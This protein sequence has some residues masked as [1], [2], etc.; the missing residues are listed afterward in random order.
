[1]EK[2]IDMIFKI[3]NLKNKVSVVTGGNSH[4]GTAM[5]EILLQAESK[6]YIL[7]KSQKKLE[8]SKKEL[9]SKGYENFEIMKVD[10]SKLSSIQ[11][12]FENIKKESKKIDVLINNAY[13]GA[14][15]NFENKTEKQ[16]NEGINGT[17]NSVFR[18]TKAI[19]P[20]MRKQKSGSIINIASMYGSISP[21]PS[22]YE[23]SGYDSPPEYGSGKA[24][25]IQFTKYIAIHNAKLGIRV[26]SISPGAFPDKEVQKN[27][28]FINNLKKKI[29]MGRI[30]KPDELKGVIIFLASN[31]S[32]YVTGENI[33]IDGGWTAW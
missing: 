3:F 24:A 30:G 29:P 17:I 21:D 13:F 11:K 20:I 22:I 28:K 1:M 19:L 33:H 23:K 26:N 32:S 9:E 18:T 25:I 12:S 6:V 8:I 7:G 14:N 5:S 2:Y 31:A 15:G 27:K 4:L 10:I 16:W